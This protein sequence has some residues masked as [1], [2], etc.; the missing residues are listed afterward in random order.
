MKKFHMPTAY[1]ILFLLLFLV[2]AATWVIPAGEYQREGED[3]VPVAGTYARVEQQPQGVGDVIQASFHGFYD[4]VDVAL[5]ILMV[6]GFLGVVMKTGAIDAG[7]SNVIRILGGREILLIPVMMV[8]FSLGGT[9]FGM[10]EETMAFYPLLIPVFV[11]AGYDP[12]VGIAVVLLGSGAG[13][14]AS[15]VNPF[16]TGIASG[17]AGVSLGDGL[18][19]R[20]VML[21]VFDAAAIWYVMHYA[22]K[23]R[24]HPERS[25]VAGFSRK[26]ESKKGG[27][28]PDLNGKRKLTLLLFAGVFLVMVYAVIPFDEI[29]LPLPALHWWFPEL[30]GLFLGGAVVIGL[31]YGLKEQELVDSFVSGAADLVGVAFIIGIS[32]GI[33]VLMDGGKITDTVLYWGEHALEGAGSVG[34]ILL[35]YLIYL[36]LSILIPSSSGLATLSVP[37]MAPLGQFAGIGGELIVTA[38]QSASGLVNIVTPTA[39]VV[40]GGLALG[41]VPYDRWVKF[42]WK[43][44]LIFFL[45]TI[46]FLMVSAVL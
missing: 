15:T 5:F 17:F 29:G 27:D 13:V 43:L 40:M 19:V 8:L 35:V 12:L 21:A 11:A 2:A 42:V 10:W 26:F 22:A 32:R 18:M 1:T 44:I 25:L 3:E 41:D 39:A 45:L 34:F 16:A 30:S 37:I 33:T 9:S 31:V 36:P 7:V 6:G 46:A 4:A 20:L 38:F 28:V 23:V 14:L 24:S